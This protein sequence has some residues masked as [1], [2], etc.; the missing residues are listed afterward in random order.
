MTT[1]QNNS[2]RKTAVAW[3]PSMCRKPVTWNLQ[4]QRTSSIPVRTEHNL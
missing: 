4:R 3:S 1:G 2:A